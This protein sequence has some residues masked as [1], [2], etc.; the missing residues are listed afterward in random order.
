M[1]LYPD[2]LAGFIP[3]KK[4]VK[5]KLFFDPRILLVA[6]VNTEVGEW[7]VYVGVIN[8]ADDWKV[9]VQLVKETGNKVSE[10]LAKLY[11]PEFKEYRWR[12]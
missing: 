1:G 8:E 6:S 11:F 9:N 5:G 10:G 4:I 12:S 7:T 2:D 3:E